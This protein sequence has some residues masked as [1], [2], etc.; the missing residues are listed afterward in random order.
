[1]ERTIR[2][3]LASEEVKEKLLLCLFSFYL[4]GYQC[5]RRLDVIH[6]S[7]SPPDKFFQMFH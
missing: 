4:A 6:L 5:L 7:D 2:K 3:R 1:M